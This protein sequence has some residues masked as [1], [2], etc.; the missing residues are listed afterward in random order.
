M[1]DLEV[2]EHEIPLV[3]IC[4]DEAHQNYT[5]KLAAGST[6]G[7]TAFAVAVLARSLAKEGY[8]EVDDFID[9]VQNYATDPQYSAVDDVTIEEDDGD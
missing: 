8:I 1:A 7:E 9:R 5:V 6:V 2:V 3:E 4:C